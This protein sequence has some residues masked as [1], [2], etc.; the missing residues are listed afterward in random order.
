LTKSDSD[1][2]SIPITFEDF[3][4]ESMT[5]Y[6]NLEEDIPWDS[7]TVAFYD[8]IPMNHKGKEPHTQKPRTKKSKKLL[9]SLCHPKIEGKL[10]SEV[11]EG[12]EELT[13]PV[14]KVEHKQKIRRT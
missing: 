2:G 6:D 5:Y 11:D 12:P 3:I 8:E 4:P 7:L 1:L 10:E 14:F 13:Q 9:K